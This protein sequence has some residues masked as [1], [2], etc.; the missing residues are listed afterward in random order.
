[1]TLAQVITRMKEIA[2]KQPAVSLIIDNDIFRLNATPDARYGVFAYTQQTHSGTVD[3]NF[4]RFAFTLFYVDRLNEDRS[5]EIEVQ[6]VGVQVLESIIRT[7]AEEGIYAG[8]YTIQTFTQRF[9]D[10]CAG[11]FANAT[12]EVL[13]DTLCVED[14]EKVIGND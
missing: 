10:E 7:L 11:A 5:N 13:Q 1:M 2:G 9:L 14:Y 4:H 6:S 12:F 8:D 3:G